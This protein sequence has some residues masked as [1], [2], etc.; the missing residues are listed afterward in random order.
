MISNVVNPRINHHNPPHSPTIWRSLY[1]IHNWLVVWL[2]FFI[3]P[4]ILGIIIPTDSYFSE[5]WPNHQTDKKRA[6]FM[7]LKLRDGSFF[8]FL[9]DHHD[10]FSAQ[11]TWPI[12]WTSVLSGAKEELL[13][14]RGKQRSSQAGMQR[15][16]NVHIE[17]VVTVHLGIGSSTVHS[18]SWVFWI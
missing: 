18:Y 11:E 2:P 1:I 15:G 5:G 6:I 13:P 17:F 4:L 16:G 7:K 8:A 10:F 3:F 14:R 12:I 9:V